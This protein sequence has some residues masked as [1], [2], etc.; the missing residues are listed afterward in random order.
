MANVLD[1]VE[2]WA[3]RRGSSNQSAVREYVRVWRIRVDEATAGSVEILSLASEQP[4]F[5]QILA[6]SYTDGYST[7][8]DV[9][10]MAVKVTASQ[11]AEDPQ[12][13]DLAVDYT[14]DRQNP[15]FR[16]F[17]TDNPLLRPPMFSL[18]TNRYSEIIYSDAFGNPLRNSAG[19][20]FVPAPEA[21]RCRLVLS[22]SRFELTPNMS[23]IAQYQD[24][25]NSDVFFGYQPG[26]CKIAI[27]AESHLENDI[28]CFHMTYSIEIRDLIPVATPA[29][30]SSGGAGTTNV[31]PWDLLLL[32]HGPHELDG[33]GNPKAVFD[34]Q[35]VQLSDL[36]LNLAGAWIT[37]ES[38]AEGLG[39]RYYQKQIYNRLPYAALNLPQLL[40]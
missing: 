34:S 13:W 28:Y 35:G 12:T 30:Q 19:E 11:L 10:A 7:F 3:G 27:A 25:V 23:L 39:Y 17:V 33:S 40:S 8:V 32:D 18:S 16:Q 22:I 38:D 26:Q 15:A 9:G 24:A 6:D 5:P 1:F 37:E 14:S 4:G 21:D 2:I 31:S 20:V 36:T 29:L